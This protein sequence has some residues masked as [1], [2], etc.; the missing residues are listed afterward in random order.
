MHNQASERKAIEDAL[1][2]A[3]AKDELTLLYQPIVDVAREQ[4]T[5]FEALIRWR[6]GDGKVVSPSK[7]IPI[8]ED[9]NLIVPNGEWIRRHPCDTVARPGPGYRVALNGQRHP[10]ANATLPAHIKRA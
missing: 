8:A 4:I 10:F 1:R 3:L 9:S 6:R 5:G 7:F 2:D